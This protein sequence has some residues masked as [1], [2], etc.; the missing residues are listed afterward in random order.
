MKHTYTLLVASAALEPERHGTGSVEM[1]AGGAGVVEG[2]CA[3]A[4]SRSGIGAARDKG[5]AGNE[6]GVYVLHVTTSRRDGARQS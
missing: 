5:G 2:E 3:A 6:Q 1:S 4:A